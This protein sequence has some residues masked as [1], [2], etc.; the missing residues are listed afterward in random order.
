MEFD[1]H[2]HTI[3]SG[4]ATSCTITDMAK[5]AAKAGLKMIGI[6]DHGPD[7]VNAGTPSYF[8]SLSYAP[9]KRCGIDILYGVE[10][11]I[12]DYEGKVDLADE[13]LAGLDYALI[14]MHTLNIEPGTRRQ[15]TNAYIN[16]MNHP[17]V[18]IIGHCDDPKFPVDYELLMNAAVKN[19]V[20]FEIN[21]SSLRPDGYRGD[22]IANNREILKQCRRH[23][24][25]VILSSDSH[26]AEH[27]G[28]FRCALELV[29]QME[30]P[31]HLIANK[32]Y[33]AFTSRL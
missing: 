17:N 16:A 29:K 26:G 2:L 14:S 9:R 8:R 32:D 4:H 12:M 7:T 28:D 5:K 24:Y 30:F 15:N 33:A 20:F 21:N 23:D 1:L 18:R 25:P 13:I 22:T 10:L 31:E 27:V 6:S 11:N 19:R 3:A